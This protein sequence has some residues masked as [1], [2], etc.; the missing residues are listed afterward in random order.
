M[1][2][3]L[4]R[5]RSRASAPTAKGSSATI[6]GMI[7]TV[8]AGAVLLCCS[9]LLLRLLLP[10]QWRYRL[11]QQL[12]RGWTRLRLMASEWPRQWLRR[13]RSSREAHD[14]IERARHRAAGE[15]NV[16]REGNVY[17]H[18]RFKPPA[19]RDTLH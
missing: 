8:L 15:R 2:A 11:D 4:A 13:R 5:G 12:R 1:R 3:L 14:V 10:A 16:Q 18:D 9:V 19:D 7:E 6:C 17:R